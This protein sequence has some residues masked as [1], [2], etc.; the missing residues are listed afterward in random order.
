MSDI[1]PNSFEEDRES[2]VKALDAAKAKATEHRGLEWVRR[3]A[4]EI[5]ATADV[6]NLVC[7]ADV[8]ATIVYQILHNGE[9][10]DAERLIRAV[11]DEKAPGKLVMRSG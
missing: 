5:R 6:V 10:P 9:F 7:D 2:W 11:E 8:S 4:E 1:P 3:A